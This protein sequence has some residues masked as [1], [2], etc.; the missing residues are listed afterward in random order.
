MKSTFFPGPSKV[1][2]Q[3]G[4]YMQD[5]FSQGILSLNHRSKEFMAICENTVRLMH[6]KLNIPSDY[7]I[8]F[9][10]SSTECW[11][12]HAQSLVAKQSHHL[13]NGAFGKKWFEYAKNLRPASTGVAFSYDS[14][15]LSQLETLPKKAEW[16]C[17]TQNETSNGTQ[18]RPSDLQKIRKQFPH[19][20]IAADATSSLGGIDVG[21]AHAD[22]WHAS[23]QK[24]LGLPAGLG[25]MICSPKAMEKAKQVN[26]TGVYNT[27]LNIAKN[28]EQFQTA[29]TP[30]VLGIYLLMRVLESLPTIAEVEAKLVKRRAAWHRFFAPF[31]QLKVLTPQE[32]MASDTVICVQ[33]E[34]SLVKEI[35]EKGKK[36]DILIGGGYGDL[37][38]E[39]FRIAN[40]P[41]ISEA[42]IIRLK[43]FLKKHVK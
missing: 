20:L 29:Y 13:Y 42:E 9:T 38:P 10:S 35:I 6:E 1:Y 2:P 16:L 32:S 40:F 23:V 7:R 12:I 3:V 18:V 26:H 30:N 36:E 39:T 15:V 34:P 5:A 17:I 31:A 22:F 25:I 43:R 41:A 37:K 19:L 21:I 11:E 28:M 24:C 27:L 8:F 33:A 4:R 14:S